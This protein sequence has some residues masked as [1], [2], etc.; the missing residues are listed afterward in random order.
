MF[1][2]HFSNNGSITTKNT[3]AK[4]LIS[5]LPNAALNEFFPRCYDL[6]YD[7]ERKAFKNDFEQNQFF[8]VLKQTFEF[9]QEKLPDEVGAL[10]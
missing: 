4:N 5:F 10:V 3:L 9:F 8:S 7:L 6:S 1:F 2:N